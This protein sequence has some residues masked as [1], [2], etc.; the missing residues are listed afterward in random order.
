VLCATD[1]TPR[2]KAALKAAMSLADRLALQLT[3]LHVM[4][5]GQS[6]A[7]RLA[8]ERLADQLKN[9]A[10]RLKT[11]PALAIRCG[12]PARTIAQV[13]RETGAQLIILGAQRKR[14]LASLLGTTA[15]RVL[16]LTRRPM[17]IVRSNSRLPYDNVVVG[18][19][20]NTDVKELM[21]FAAQ[22]SFLERSRVSILHGFQSPFQGPL[23]AEGYDV[24]AARKHIA[25]WKR[26][27]HSHLLKELD[28]AQLDG[29]S[30]E[31]RIEE[32]RPLRLV[33]RALRDGARSLLILGASEHTAL[34]R[35]VRGSLAND[36]LLRLDCDVLMWPTKGSR[37]PRH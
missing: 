8:E 27:T 34:T 14:T 20:L 7:T 25:R 11:V 19:K 17:L 9:F 6:R 24:V 26:A 2:S 21:R 10:H 35:L 1:L 3:L 5:R 15:E 12:D 32:E 29:A 30:F 4:K 36:A 13:A 28:A 18:A 31:V 33:R 22:W 16:A 37:V 23:Y